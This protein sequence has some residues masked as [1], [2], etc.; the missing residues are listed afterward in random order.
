MTTDTQTSTTTEY[1]HPGVS[2]LR[3]AKGVVA[4][5]KVT[6]R[7]NPHNVIQD[8]I[9]PDSPHVDSTMATDSNQ[10]TVQQPSNP[11][12]TTQT[13]DTT[14]VDWEK[15]YSDARRYQQE[16]TDKIKDLES[17]LTSETKESI[18]PKSDVELEKWKSEHPELYDAVVTVYR[19]ETE[20]INT[21]LEK[22]KA[23][24][25][26]IRTSNK[27]ESVFNEVLKVHS[28]ADSIRRSGE[29]KE[30][31]TT[32]SSGVQSLIDSLDSRDIVKG[33]SL[34]KADKGL[35]TQGK[36]PTNPYKSAE[37]AGAVDVNNSTQLPTQPKAW[38]PEEVKQLSPEQYAK[39]RTAIK[40]Y[41]AG[42]KR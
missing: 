41:F 4:T 10:D 13:S 24:L 28:D 32:Q 34:Y 26:Q 36:P 29:F 17:K 2:A 16:L 20:Q 9:T 21:E 5:P 33:I 19:K 35:T 37:A 42:N 6:N 40:E 30:W 22:A 12:P 25:E 23:E 27:K 7:T 15:R 8:R 11:E 1:S 38:T 31:Y 39:H 3:R 18:L 14:N